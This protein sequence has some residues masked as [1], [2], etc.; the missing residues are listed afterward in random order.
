MAKIESIRFNGRTTSE[1]R[2]QYRQWYEDNWA[3]VSIRHNRSDEVEGRRD[4]A[5]A[6]MPRKGATTRQR[7]DDTT[8]KDGRQ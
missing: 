2:K 8:D 5:P 1:V 4:A 3:E 6:A 7:S